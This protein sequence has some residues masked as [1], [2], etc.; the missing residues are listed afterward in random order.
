MRTIAE[1]NLP[2]TAVKVLGEFVEFVGF[3]RGLRPLR[4]FVLRRVAD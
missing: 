2:L 3:R 1:C 4:C